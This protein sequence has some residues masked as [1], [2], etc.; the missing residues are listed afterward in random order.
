MKGV[1]GKVLHVDLSGSKIESKTLEEPTLKSY[2]GGIGLAAR[3]L[4][5][6]G[7]RVNP[8]GSENPLI[9]APGL[10]VGTGFPTASKTIFAA[11]S[12]L[13]GGIGRAAVG[14]W[15]GV[16]LKK[17]GFDAL[18]IEGRA[19]TPA[20]LH[21]DDGSSSIED[22]SE[23]WGLKVREA[24]GKIKDRYEG[25]STAVIG[26]AGER[27]SLIAGIDCEE[28]QAARTGLGAVMGSKKLKAIAV[29]GTGK[30]EYAN[31]DSLRA[32]SLK[33]SKTLREDPKS[34]LQRKYGTP[35]FYDWMNRDRG[36]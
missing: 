24:A 35:E 23:L 7:G 16:A 11:K 5:D 29:K 12:P 33:W 10:L 19:E 34:E 8:L 14:A 28:R 32:L 31:P 22:A 21:I 18:I 1:A 9:M 17:A 36:V 13:T 6:R 3:I 20:I 15:V 27:L 30:I 26:P 25:V 4:Y 2:L